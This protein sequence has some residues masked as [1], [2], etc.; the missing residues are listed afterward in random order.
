MDLYR[1]NPLLLTL[2]FALLLSCNQVQAK[3]R[4][5]FKVASIAP[6][7]SIW[8]KRFHD[9]AAEVGRRSDNAIGFKVYPGGIMGD[10]RAVY[11]KMR[12]GQLQGG[13]FTMT[14]IGSVVPDFR[15]MGIPFLF[16]SYQEVDHVRKGLWPF[17]SSAFAA[18][19]L[20]LIA[21][22]EV[23][24]VYSMS[25][26]P[27]STL[28]QLRKSKI[29][30]PENDPVSI[31][32]LETLGITPLPLAIPD[33]LT[34]L[35]TGMLETV[36]NSLYGAIVMQWFTKTNYISD[37][38]FGYAYGALLLDR[39]RFAS[40]PQAD[41]AMIKE[42]ANKHFSLLVSDTRESN[43][44]SRQVLRDNGVSMV[45]PEAG[46]VEELTRMRDRTVERLQDT[47]FSLQVYQT[48]MQLLREYRQQAR[49]EQA[50]PGKE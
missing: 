47:A 41:Q 6:E 32:Y 29:W 15:V 33:V 17:F 3:P 16:H 22:T 34:S 13:G 23:G 24:F 4:Y 18:Q 43:R 26:S 28:K 31:A 37:I 14:G 39:K 25:T 40:L 1:R 45:A 44:D 2:F 49:T 42:T 48:T 8:I 12:I 5:L 36:F 38:P 30:A 20:E 10:D 50:E 27:L 9:F 35:Q 11:R 7:G 46:E 21:M 19:G